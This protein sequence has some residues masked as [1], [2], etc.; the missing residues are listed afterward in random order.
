MNSIHQSILFSVL[1]HGLLVVS[2]LFVKFTSEQVDIPEF[3][4][5]VLIDRFEPLKPIVTPAP[6][7]SSSNSS[8]GDEQYTPPST[9]TIINV[10]DVSSPN[11]EPVDISNLPERADK[12]TPGNT[13]NQTS[14]LDHLL[15]PNLNQTNVSNNL[16][17]G[18]TNTGTG[19][20][21]DGLGEEIRTQTGKFGHW[22]MKGEIINRTIIR[23]VLPEFPPNIQKNGVVTIQ[24]NVLPNG[25][26]QNPVI[27]RK[28][29]PEFEV[30]AISSI[31]QW[32][33]NIADKTHTGQISFNFKLE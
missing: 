17:I 14:V 9:S 30:A 21:L 8:L 2:M 15:Q 23:Q 7:A 24:F 18:Q 19:I 11:F 1:F 5:V 20:T 28:S 16:N 32:V 31:R 26:V 27:T 4:E 33:F 3:I 10:P 29:E 13:N 12:N 22:E 6:S 25:S